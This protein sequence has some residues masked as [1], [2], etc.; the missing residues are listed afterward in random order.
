MWFQKI[1][2]PTPRRVSGNYKG[3]GGGVSQK[4]KVLKE[5]EFPEGLGGRFKPKGYGC[6][7][8]PHNSLRLNNTLLCKEQIHQ[9]QQENADWHNKLSNVPVCANAVHSHCGIKS[10]S[11]QFDLIRNMSTCLKK[12]GHSWYDLLSKKN[13]SHN[14]SNAQGCQK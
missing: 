9:R 12:M 13:L 7:L 2:I 4:P 10:S 14:A 8:G 11:N 3:F 1:T 6:F 5:L